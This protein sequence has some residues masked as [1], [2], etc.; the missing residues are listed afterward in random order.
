MPVSVSWIR[1]GDNLAA[2]CSRHPAE[3]SAESESGACV[4]PGPKS[5][6]IQGLYDSY[7]GP[8]ARGQLPVSAGCGHFA[9]VDK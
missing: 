3:S 8:S 2:P 5:M 9:R 6:R 1:H 7:N 4:D